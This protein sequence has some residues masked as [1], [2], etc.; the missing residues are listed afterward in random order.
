MRFWHVGP[1]ILRREGEVEEAWSRIRRSHITLSS[2]GQW[3]VVTMRPCS[4]SGKCTPM[5]FGFSGLLPRTCVQLRSASLMRTP[6]LQNCVTNRSWQDFTWN[7]ATTIG[8]ISGWSTAS[9]WRMETPTYTVAHVIAA[10]L[11]RTLWVRLQK[12]QRLC[13]PAPFRCGFWNGTCSC[14]ERCFP[15]MTSSLSQADWI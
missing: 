15:M 11:T 14:A 7:Q 5:G 6:A 9:V 12:S 10:K 13:T 2:L 4:S 3:Q 1:T 8:T